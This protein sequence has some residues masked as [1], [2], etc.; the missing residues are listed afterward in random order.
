LGLAER[1]ASK[2]RKDLAKAVDGVLRRAIKNSVGGVKKKR[3]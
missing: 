3:L 2:D 1:T